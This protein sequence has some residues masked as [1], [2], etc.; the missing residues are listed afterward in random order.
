ME[1]IKVAIIK[2]YIYNRALK[3]GLRLFAYLKFGMNI[4]QNT[5]CKTYNMSQ[6]LKYFRDSRNSLRNLHACQFF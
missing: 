2:K 3:R 4:H 5:K 1:V 6:N